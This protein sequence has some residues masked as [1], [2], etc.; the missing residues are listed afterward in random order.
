MHTFTGSTRFWAVLCGLVI[1]GCVAGAAVLYHVIFTQKGAEKV[2]GYTV[3]T[4]DDM[5]MGVSYGEVTGSLAEGITVK[6][7]HVGNI[8]LLP[9]GSEVNIGS[10]LI[11][12]SP[13]KEEWLSCM[14]NK[15]K[16]SIP[17]SDPVTFFGKITTGEL[18]IDVYCNALNITTTSG[19]K[20]LKWLSKINA[21]MRDIDI[22]VKG[23]PETPEIKGKLKLKNLLRNGIIVR[24]CDI[25]IDMAIEAG[26]DPVKLKGSALFENGEVVSPRTILKLRRSILRFY[27]APELTGL[28]ISASA[29]VEDVKIDIGIAGSVSAPEVK[30]ASTPRMEEER[31]LLMLATGRRWDSLEGSVANKKMGPDVAKDLVEYLFVDPSG[32]GFLEEMGITRVDIKFDENTSGLSVK[33]KMTDKTALITG[34]EKR[35]KA[36]IPAGDRYAVG[37]EY[38]LQENLSIEGVK[39]IDPAD[40]G[41]GA[42]KAPD[43]D[44]VMVKYR[45][46]F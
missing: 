24:G 23:A 43:E 18:D 17:R 45:T 22:K 9:E 37:A 39:K 1:A 16:V 4:Y 25:T 26:T 10:A 2:L 21:D 31:I 42:G 30:L 36:G 32:D 6:D 15:G 19:V 44:E 40:P 7:I 35:E 46:K 8:K 38:K 5:M 28:D 34:Y 29:E 41:Q 3:A 33:K 20:D 11:S 12:F 13:G 27:G 14:V